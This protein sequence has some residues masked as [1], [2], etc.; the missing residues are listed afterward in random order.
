M[1]A[2]LVLSLAGQ[3]KLRL[4]Q[5]EVASLVDCEPGQIL[6]LLFALSELPKSDDPQIRTAAAELQLEVGEL[7]APHIDR[8]LDPPQR[9]AF[10][11]IESTALVDAGRRAEA[12]SSLRDLVEKNP[13]SG[14]TRERYAQLLLAG[15]DQGS[16]KKALNQWRLIERGSR[17]ATPRW[18]EAK[19]GIAHAH[20]KLGNRQQAARVVTL[21][22]ALHPKL[23]G[24]TMK[25]RFESLLARCQ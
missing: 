25:A 21:L 2:A 3:R 7:I 13:R 10:R 14:Q 19:Y 1:R 11:R 8:T 5:A 17:T 15:D 18:Y 20:E 24:A 23:G 22:R 12:L 16:L 9:E 6:T 4:A